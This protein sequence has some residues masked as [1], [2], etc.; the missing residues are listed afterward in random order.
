MQLRT[1]DVVVPDVVEATRF[2]TDILGLAVREADERFAELEAG[3]DMTLMLT[4]DL[5]VPSSPARGV[6]L[7]FE[8]ADVQREVDR[9]TA[10]GVAVLLPLT[11][12]DWGTEMAML[13]GPEGVVISLFKVTIS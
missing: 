6:V 13:Q 9:M 1:M 4:P 12:T 5:M 7:H 3:T 11:A 10:A 2:F 8:V